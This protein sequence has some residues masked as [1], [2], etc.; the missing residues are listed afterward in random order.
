MP[1]QNSDVKEIFNKMADLLEIEGANPFRVRAYRNAARTVSDLSKNV[2]EMIE[3][4]EDL[5]ELSGIGEDLA[6]KIE[7]IVKTGALS[8]LKK[9]QEET[10]PQLHELMKLE[11]LGP[12][13]VRVLNRELN[14]EGAW[15]S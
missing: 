7:E 2:T 10:P 9:L 6:G 11:G 15:I 14:I 5:T 3:D 1:V 13:R 12:K 8:Q 4:N